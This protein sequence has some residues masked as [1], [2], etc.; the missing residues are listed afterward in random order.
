MK[1]VLVLAFSVLSAG[2][3]WAATLSEIR[4]G[5][6]PGT[7]RLE[8]LDKNGESIPMAE[9]GKIIRI[10]WQ[11]EKTK[12]NSESLN[13]KITNLTAGTQLFQIKCSVTFEPKNIMVY[14]GLTTFEAT[15]CTGN[16]LSTDETY[17]LPVI[18]AWN[19]RNGVGIAA[20]AND[21]HSRVLP[22]ITRNPDNSVT[23]GSVVFAA[24]LKRD[25][26]YHGKFLLINFNPK[27]QER[28]CLARYYLHYPELFVQRANID[29]RLYGIPAMYGSWV[30]SNPEMCRISGGAWD[31]CIFPTRRTGEIDDSHWDYTPPRPF[32]INASA[33]YS[34]R[35]T[36]MRVNKDAN[37]SREKWLE[38]Q[39]YKLQNA[40]Y[41]NVANGFY[42]CPNWVEESL[43][44]QYPDAL[45]T[46]HSMDDT[47][48]YC[49]GQ[50]QDAAMAMFPFPETTWGVEVRRMLKAVADRSSPISAFAYD[51]TAGG[52]RYRGPVLEKMKNVAWD[53]FG[54]YVA[55][56]V[57]NAKLYD[58]VRTLNNNAKPL[59][60][61]NNT[62][63]FGNYQDCF[64]TDSTIIEGRPWRDAPPWPK[65]SRYA[66]GEKAIA[67]WCD[68]GLNAMVKVDDISSEDC[69]DAFRGLADY[70]AHNSFRWGVT[71]TMYLSYGSEYLLRLIPALKDCVKAA[72][73]AVPGAIVD[74][75]KVSVA[76]Y[77]TGLNSFLALGAYSREDQ[78]AH[79][80]I[81]PSELWGNIIPD[82]TMSAKPIIFADYYGNRITNSIR[83][84]SDTISVMIKGRKVCVLESVAALRDNVSGDVVAEEDKTFE[85]LVVTLK[86]KNGAGQIEVP[87]QRNTYV[88]EGSSTIEAAGKDAV[89]VVYKNRM[90]GTTVKQ[91]GTFKYLN[92]DLTPNC[93]VVCSGDEELKYLGARLNSFFRSYVKFKKNLATY[94]EVG[95]KLNVSLDKTLPDHTILLE[96][97]N[98][99][100]KLFTDAMVGKHAYI[101]GVPEQGLIVLSGKSYH[102][103]EDAVAT[104]LNVLNRNIYPDYI[105]RRWDKG[106]K[107]KSFYLLPDERAMFKCNL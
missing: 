11:K 71:Y 68:L 70:T 35:E 97:N 80:E 58:Y 74:N 73:K 36:G 54:P 93:T 33:S 78:T 107:S 18:A 28:D 13:Y 91:M 8:L 102:E 76:R 64:F 104:F 79:V 19:A 65:A 103:L 75:P 66:M 50:Q 23:L 94:P 88:L 25:S 95:F 90:A 51:A 63:V 62:H 45:A 87:S 59:G 55:H 2:G 46:L 99:A 15:T 106:I 85:R 81:F 92:G 27:Y 4:D 86:L 72:W 82:K 61:L 48:R 47:W 12:N 89:S 57:S 96:Q 56:G 52:Q 39:D 40:K 43:A 83:G 100:R 10:D 31:W 53:E 60:V 105:G 5:M 3:T 37:M 22:Q 49:Y 38:I 14:D 32:T 7:I 84:K 69:E 9:L 16:K 77:G 29:Q 21:F 26:L 30:E 42:N 20:G 67:W 41:C 6:F 24:L 98:D 1:R 101:S 34:D 17:L 44:K